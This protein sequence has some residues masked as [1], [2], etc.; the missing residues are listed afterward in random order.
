MNASP[1]LSNLAVHNRIWNL[2]A[3]YHTHFSYNSLERRSDLY[4]VAQHE[5]IVS[6]NLGYIMQSVGVDTCRWSF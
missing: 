4:Y 1:L 2:A 3:K 5:K 6:Y